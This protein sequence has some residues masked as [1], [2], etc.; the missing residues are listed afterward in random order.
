[1]TETYCEVGKGA[2]EP[3]RRLCTNPGQNDGD[4]SQSDG[5]GGGEKRP[6]AGYNLKVESEVLLID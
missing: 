5:S 4:R 6:D 1:M 2:R 3:A